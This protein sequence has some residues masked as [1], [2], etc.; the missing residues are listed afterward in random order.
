[1][2]NITTLQLFAINSYLGSSFY[3]RMY[4]LS[5]FSN[6]RKEKDEKKTQKEK[7]QRVQVPSYTCYVHCIILSIIKRVFCAY[8]RYFIFGWLSDCYFNSFLLILFVLFCCC[9]FFFEISNI[10]NKNE[11]EKNRTFQSSHFKLCCCFFS[12]SSHLTYIST[13]VLIDWSGWNATTTTLLL[14]AHSKVIW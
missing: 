10:S 1:M 3:L 8:V 7:K 11:R 4:Q 9:L 13:H 14:L 12:L 5:R 2:T 6:T